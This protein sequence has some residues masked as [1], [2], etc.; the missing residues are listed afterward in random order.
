MGKGL[1][2]DCSVGY[3]FAAQRV[4]PGFPKPRFPS[5]LKSSEVTRRDVAGPGVV[6]FFVCFL[7]L[8]TRSFCGGVLVFFW[9]WSDPMLLVLFVVDKVSQQLTWQ[10]SAIWHREREQ[11][12]QSTSLRVAIMKHGFIWILWIGATS[13]PIKIIMMGTFASKNALRI[14]HTGPKSGI[15]ARL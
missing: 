2:R 4:D 14:L 9:S 3:K 15:L 10:N 12:R 6:R 13:G 7:W 1:F 5:R 11:R 8:D